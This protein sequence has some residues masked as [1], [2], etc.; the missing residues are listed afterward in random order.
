MGVN[1]DAMQRLLDALPE[2]I[3]AAIGALLTHIWHRY[4]SRMTALRWQA[5][6][7]PLGVSAQDALF[8][9]IEVRYNGQPVHNLFFTTIDLQNQSNADLKEVDLNLVFQDGT[10]IYMAHGEVHGSANMLPFAEPFNSDLNR[11]LGLQ[12]Q[13]PNR[14]A[15]GAALSRRRD[16]RVPVLN[17]G[18]SLRI[19][20]LVE[21]QPGQRP[22][23]NLACDHAGVKLL[24]QGPQDLLFGVQRG[25]AAVTGL[26]AALATVIILV[27]SPI[28]TTATAF[29]ALALGS[30]TAAIGAGLIRSFRW[31]LRLLS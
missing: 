1:A 4:R 15:L 27:A 30:L 17:R 22:F 23:V 14:P 24:F 13:D 18:A 11:F 9:T 25:L 29:I 31:F 21:A 7:L 2:A 3:W 19:A 16:F 20:M 26:T 6:H 12:P 5:A 8:G 28:N 10:I